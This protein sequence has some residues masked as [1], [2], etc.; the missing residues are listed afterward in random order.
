MNNVFKSLRMTK[1]PSE[2][3]DYKIKQLSLDLGI[4]APK[5]SELEHGRKASLTELQAYHNYFKVPYEYLLGEVD[6]PHYEYMV[7]SKDLGLN[8]ESLKTLRTLTK[9]PTYARILNSFIKKY[10][11]QILSEISIGTQ[12]MELVTATV[13]NNEHESRQKISE[14]AENKAMQVLQDITNQTGEIIRMISGNDNIDYCKS[15]TSELMRKAVENIL[16]YWG[17][18]KE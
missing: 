17:S 5:I 13:L 7:A 2:F 6:S 1:N 14:E 8:G 4:S 10:L 3:E 12:Y 18:D 11:Q 15:R 9:N 16:Y